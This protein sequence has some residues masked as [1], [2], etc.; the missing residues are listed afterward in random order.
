M[1]SLKGAIGHC[2]GA[3]GAI[4]TVMGVL[5]IADQTVPPTLNYTT[6]DPAVG[7]DV[8]HGEPRHVDFDVMVKHS[9]GL[10]GQNAALVIGRAPPD[11]CAS[12]K[13]LTPSPSPNVG[14]GEHEGSRRRRTKVAS[15]QDV[16][17]FVRMTKNKI[18]K[19][20]LVPVEG[21]RPVR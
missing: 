20:S 12:E 14:R 11:W 17:P 5:S 2:M 19:R 15:R 8:V 1:T 4:E 6:P 9:F 3:A 16:F 21:E 13:A 18:E 7:L 10:G